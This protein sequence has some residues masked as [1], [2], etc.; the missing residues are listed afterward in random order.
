[1]WVRFFPHAEHVRKVFRGDA[2]PRIEIRRTD[3]IISQLT[4]SPTGLSVSDL[5]LDFFLFF[6]SSFF[7]R[8]FSLLYSLVSAAG[9][10]DALKLKTLEMG[11]SRHLSFLSFYLFLSFSL[12][13]PTV[14]RRTSR[15]KG[16]RTERKG[17]S[18]DVGC[19]SSYSFGSRVCGGGPRPV[20]RMRGKPATRNAENLVLAWSARGNPHCRGSTN[21]DSPFSWKILRDILSEAAVYLPAALLYALRDY[22]VIVEKFDW[23]ICIAKI[24][25]LYLEYIVEFRI[26]SLCDYSIYEIYDMTAIVINKLRKINRLF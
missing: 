10:D 11:H 13:V 21:R 8:R 19:H 12:F 7:F 2:L 23:K 15:W 25:K 14:L 16:S 26:I 22:E 1:M 18:F 24:V 5:S 20:G 6:L 3:K 4:K 17:S 9:S